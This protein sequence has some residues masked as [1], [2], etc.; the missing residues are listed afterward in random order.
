MSFTPQ[1]DGTPWSRILELQERIYP[2]WRSVKS[3]KHNQL[4]LFGIDPQPTVNQY[5]S[6][7]IDASNLMRQTQEDC[8]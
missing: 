6:G 5:R 4:V 7:V 1:E 3:R 2:G 8:K